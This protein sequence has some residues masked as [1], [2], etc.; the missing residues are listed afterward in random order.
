MLTS[1][2][3]KLA[4]AAVLALLAAAG[5][6]HAAGSPLGIG[7]AEP[8]FQP[9]GGPLA[10]IFLYVNYEQQAFYRALTRSIEA[11]RQDPWQLWTLI[12]LSFAYGI[13]HAAGPGHG[14]A[15]ISSYMVANEIELKRGIGISFVSALIQGLVAVL[16]VGAAYF[17]L[18]GSGIT[19]TMATNAMEITSFVMVILF[20]SWLLFRKLRAMMQSRAQ[21]QEMQL[22]TSAGPI[23]V[24]LFEG[25]AT[26]TDSTRGFARSGAVMSTAGGYQCYDPAH[27]AGDGA[28]CETCG[29][30]HLPDPKMLSNEKFSVREAWSAIIA[31]GLRPC[32]GALLVMTFSMLNGLY[33]GGLLSVLA[34]SIG[35][36][37]TV[38]LLAMIAVFAKGTAVRFTGKGS[39]LSAWVGNGIEILGALLVICTGVILLGASLQN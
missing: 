36:A 18:R 30:A 38:S 1:R 25:A 35:T 37:L 34:M 33:L 8:S 7:T 10:P 5:L 17:V 27:A 11:M 28:Y 14:K 23:S 4:P 22:A 2:L 26:G 3:R 15:V 24:S 21:R 6:A 19:M 29:H 9:I 16:V 32:S 39:R 31:V 20:G 13:F 12:G